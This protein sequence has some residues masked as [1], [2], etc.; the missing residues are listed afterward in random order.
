[1]TEPRKLTRDV[2]RGVLGGVCAG[3]AD[4]LN[5]DTTVV[6]VVTALIVVFSF[7]AGLLAYLVMWLIIPARTSV[8]ATISPDATAPHQSQQR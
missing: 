1:M 3:L 6:R 5:V 8:P 7:F 2:G 4:Y